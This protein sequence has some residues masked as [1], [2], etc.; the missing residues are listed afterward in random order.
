MTS[1]LITNEVTCP[2]ERVPE[3]IAAALGTSGS[4]GGLGNYRLEVPFEELGL[5]DIGKFS[6]DVEVWLGRP[7]RRPVF[8]SLE[9][10]R[11]PITWHVAGH[12]EFP[13]FEGYV[14]IT[15]LAANVTQLAIS[16]SYRPPGGPIGAAFDAT[17]GH[18]IADATIRYF[19]DALKQAIERG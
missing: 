9:E 17:F 7:E 5:P 16:G 18:R 11:L 2:A 3:R 12:P 10:T 8:A 4:T 19:L 14:E 6:R 15:P 1:V 13:T